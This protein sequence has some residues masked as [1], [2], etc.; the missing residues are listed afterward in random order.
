M[1]IHSGD[2]TSAGCSRYTISEVTALA[3]CY[4][5]SWSLDDSVTNE[6]LAAIFNPG[7]QD[8]DNPRQEPDCSYIHDELAKPG[9]NLTLLWTE[10]CE[11]ARAAG[12][13]LTCTPSSV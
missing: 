11:A 1:G 8:E 4:G 7:D 9:V 2:C 13:V 5:I 10:Y 6:T 12:K 3:E